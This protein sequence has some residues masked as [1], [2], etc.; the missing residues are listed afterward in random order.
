MVP[1]QIIL[2]GQQQTGLVQRRVKN[3]AF[4]TRLVQAGRKHRPAGRRRNPDRI[5]CGQLPVRN[6]RQPL[7]GQLTLELQRGITI[8]LFQT[9][10]TMIRLE[11]HR[12]TPTGRFRVPRLGNPVFAPHHH[13]QVTP[14]KMRF[15]RF[16]LLLQLQGARHQRKPSPERLSPRQSA[17]ILTDKTPTIQLDRPTFQLNLAPKLPVRVQI[18]AQTVTAPNP[19]M[20]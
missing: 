12:K 5:L 2:N 18:L 14:L 13:G 6:Q 8:N 10:R 1:L 4:F 11:G 9:G 3:A 17:V 19:T 15:H 20:T 7:I 16:E